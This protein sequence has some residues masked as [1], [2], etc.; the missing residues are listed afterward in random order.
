MRAPSAAS[1]P[2]ECQ[3]GRPTPVA[4]QLR[5][6]EDWG[7]ITSERASSGYRRFPRAVLRRVACIV[8]AQRIGLTLEEIGTELGKLPADRIPTRRD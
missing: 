7:L 2:H 4:L 6:Y 8:F 1:P 3:I 5:F